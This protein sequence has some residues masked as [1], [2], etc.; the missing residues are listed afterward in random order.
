MN[1][2]Y[3]CGLGSRKRYVATQS[4]KSAKRKIKKA[5]NIQDAGQ[6]EILDVLFIDTKLH[7]DKCP[8]CGGDATLKCNSRNDGTNISIFIR[9]R[10]C[11]LMVG[12]IVHKDISTTVLKVINLWNRE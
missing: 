5:F 9:C 1:N 11:G 6:I 7:L 10:S 8:I 4:I 2:I 3:L 12:R